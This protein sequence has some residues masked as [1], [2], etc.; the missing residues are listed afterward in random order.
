M[1]FK[2][3]AKNLIKC[4]IMISIFMMVFYAVPNSHA[5]ILVIGDSQ[6]DLPNAY[7]NAIDVSNLLKSKGYKVVELYKSKATSQNILKGM[8]NADAIIYAGHGGYQTGHYNTG[9]TATPPFAIMGSDDYIWGIGSKMREGWDFTRIFKA[10]IKNKIPVILIN[11]CFSTGWVG[12]KEVANPTETIYQFSKMFTG[13]GANFYATCY[14]SSIVKDILSGTRTFNEANQKS[15]E[16]INTYHLYN[17]VKIWRNSHGHVSFVGDWYGKFPTPS[18]VTSYD[19][20]A[21][22]SWYNSNR[23]SAIDLL[24]TSVIAPVQGY[25]GKT[26]YVTNSLKN[27]GV[28]SVNKSFTVTF[29]LTK[30]K[31]N[32]GMIYLGKK[33]IFGLG[34]GQTST[35]KT[36]LKIPSNVKAGL[37]YVRTMSDSGKVVN[38]FNENNNVRYSNNCLVIKN[39]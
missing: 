28:Y 19:S 13:A 22:Q 38:E 33:T 34:A 2:M 8:F 16:K 9:K 35:K 12:T 25:T 10:P 3:V 29:W 11:T 1:V 23:Q 24:P 6:S 17:G 32:A 30:Q 15:W 21:A 39:S 14:D 37:Y 27:R 31:S 36:A 18:Q 7:Q 5:H 20:S 26:V 4:M